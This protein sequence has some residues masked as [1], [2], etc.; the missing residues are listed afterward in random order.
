MPSD[1]E[2]KEL[3]EK[4]SIE[5]DEDSPEDIKRKVQV[6]ENELE[7]LSNLQWS[8]AKQLLKFGWAA[9]VF[10]VAAFVASLI[11]YQ[12]PSLVF[13]APVLSISLLIIAGAAPVIVT[14]FL[15]QKH[16]RKINRLERIR[17]GL[18]TQYES[19]LLKKMEEKIA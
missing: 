1:E 12:G 10:G 3:L 17:K 7:N 4:E 19:T 11:V 14:I 16:R 5:L 2:L 8:Y 18:L 6:V 15:I 9:W 13:N